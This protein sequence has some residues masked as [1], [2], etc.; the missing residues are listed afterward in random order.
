MTM[1]PTLTPS[2]PDPVPAILDAGSDP[3]SAVG[4]ISQRLDNV[5]AASFLSEYALAMRDE[6]NADYFAIGRLNPFS[7]IMRTLRFLDRDG[8]SENF[9]YSL[10]GT[11]CANTING[12]VCL[13][14]ENVAED[15][16]HDKEL[17]ELNICSYAGASLESAYGEKLGVIVALWKTPFQDE[18]HV[19]TLLQAFRRRVSSVIE[20]TEKVARYSWAITH[21]F[22]GVWDWDLR[23][24]G[25]IISEELRYLVSGNDKGPYDLSQLESA[26]HPDDRAN[27]VD[28]L[29]RHLN[30]GAPYD[31]KLRLRDNT[32]VY[33]WHLSR[34]AAVRG[35][36]GKPERMIGGFCDIH[37]LV[38]GLG[39]ELR[40]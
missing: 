32:G 31:L 2:I 3:Q 11:P 37:D 22:G 26:I 18:T 24:G 33:R 15:Y 12:G 10:D 28:A 19:E 34:G 20:T 40:P 5:D 16:P 8:L 27:H 14:K 35:A 17:R 4:R 30:S 13:H 29:K 39:K 38:I 23:T 6:L 36:D 21:A 1:N 7:N 9:I 25:T